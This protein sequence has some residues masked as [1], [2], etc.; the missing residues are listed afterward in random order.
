MMTALIASQDLGSLPALDDDR[1]EQ[2]CPT[3]GDE[4][5]CDKH[6]EINILFQV[7][8]DAHFM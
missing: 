7:C 8:R 6:S 2:L 3:C 5:F 1:E 4:Q